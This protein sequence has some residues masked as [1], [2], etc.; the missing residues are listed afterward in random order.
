MPETL[1]APLP[2]EAPAPPLT[3]PCWPRRRADEPA[4]VGI[5]RP[6]RGVEFDTGAVVYS[7]EACY[8]PAE[9]VEDA[10][11]R[12]REALHEA[13]HAVAVL[14]DWLSCARTFYALP[15]EDPARSALY[16]HPLAA[17]PTLGAEVAS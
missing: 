12:L 8:S 10:S 13:P 6:M 1:N 3:G 5:L 17:V 7:W 2:V 16:A 9:S 11:L 14:A 15:G 4:G